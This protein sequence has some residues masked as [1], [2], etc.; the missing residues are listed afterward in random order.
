VAGK[1]RISRDSWRQLKLSSTTGKQPD[2]RKERV[3]IGVFLLLS[4]G[5]SA[6]FWLTTSWRSLEVRIRSEFFSEKK[7]DVIREKAIIT[8]PAKRRKSTAELS[9][10]VGQY[11][12]QQP[13]DWAVWVE[14]LEDEPFVWS[15]KGEDIFP[16][17]S[18]MKLPLAVATYWAVEN[19]ELSLDQK[20][21]VKKS[22]VRRGAG[23]LQYRKL[24]AAVS[25]DRLAFLL[26]NQSDNTAFAVLS[27]IL[28]KEKISQAIDRLGMKNTSWEDFT[29]TAADQATFFR[30]LYR[31]EIL[32]E[33][34]SEKF[35]DS[36]T[37]TTFET[38]IPKGVPEG[39]RVAHKVGTEKDTISDAGVVFVPHDPFILV[40]LSKNAGQQSA[41]KAIAELTNQIYWFLV[42]D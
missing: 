19:G 27:R 39:I 15:L 3:Q 6:L 31:R 14:T 32:S 20:I 4:V 18:L 2:S 17:A 11:L 36:L 26:L 24:P 21:V 34:D 35:L 22:D 33:K 28:G 16:A 1:E 23:S 5:L 12:S 42:S 40:I 30:Q 10:M 13:G 8:Q 25:L 7:K 38:R 29:T 9:V 37:D 41:E